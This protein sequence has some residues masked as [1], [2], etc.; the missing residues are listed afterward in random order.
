VC[1]G[2]QCTGGDGVG[3][4]S[5]CSVSD[6]LPRD[7]YDPVAPV[8]LAPVPAPS[9]NDADNNGFEPV[10]F[11]VS[12][13]D[14]LQV[15]SVTCSAAG[16]VLS[17]A[18]TGGPYSF[19]GT[20]PVGLTAVQCTA[21]DF[22]PTPNSATISFEVTVKD[23]TAPVVTVP[24]ATT[25]E[26]TGPGG[27]TV[28]FGV[29]ATD[30]IDGGLTVVCS[31]S[32]GPVNPSGS[33][34]P[35]GSTLVSCSAADKGGNTATATFTVTVVDTTPPV[36]LVPANI[37]A[38]ATGA[39]GAQVT[40]V[41][42]ATDL[43]DPAPVVT[44]VPASGSLFPLGTTVVQCTAKDASGNVPVPATFTVTVAD[45]EAPSAMTATVTP[46]LLWPP[47]GRI[48][49]V[50]V[51]GEAFDGQSGV[52][53][54]SWRVAD[55]YGKHQ[56][57]GTVALAGNG[58]FSFQVPILVDRLGTDKNGRV[59]TI[60]ITVFDAAGNALGMQKPPVVVVHDQGT[61]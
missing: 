35:L 19:T 22:A 14:N 59:Y 58:A 16:L 43:V 48:A 26:A 8:V 40:F 29:S 28:N 57:T 44:C 11:T 13:T 50:F 2:S 17:P 38:R 24:T 27:A 6:G 60:H 51:S 45:S 55:E 39:T 21:T 10:T 53:R 31:T 46:S 30:V 12:A 54:L 7:I 41:A 36:L 15:K 61:K 52:A 37:T 20:F 1:T 23:V 49:N 18:A 33:L 9:V 56:P 4:A 47:D 3:G 42:S 25:A 34:F 5:E 32:G